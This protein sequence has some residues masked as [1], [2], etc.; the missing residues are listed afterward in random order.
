M[1]TSV[2]ATTALNGPADSTVPGSAIKKPNIIQKGDGDV[3]MK[4]ENEIDQKEKK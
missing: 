2:A 4:K 3:I 1:T